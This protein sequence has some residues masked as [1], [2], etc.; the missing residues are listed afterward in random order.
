MATKKLWAAGAQCRAGHPRQ[1]NHYL[2]T[3]GRGKCHQCDKLRGVKAS[4]EMARLRA[5]RAEAGVGELDGEPLHA[6][7]RLLMRRFRHG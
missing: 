7:D 2:D 1:G 4:I 5:V 3:L 6:L